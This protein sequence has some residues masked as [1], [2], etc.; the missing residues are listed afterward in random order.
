MELFLHEKLIE[1]AEPD[2]T[3]QEIYYKMNNIISDNGFIN[4]DFMGNV[5]HYI[6][7]DK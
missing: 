4:L 5:G 7:K 2:M 6:V 1:I 3:F